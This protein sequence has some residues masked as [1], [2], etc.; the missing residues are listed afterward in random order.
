MNSH[1]LKG[2]LEYRRG[3]YNDR[4]RSAGPASGPLIDSNGFVIDPVGIPGGS[5]VLNDGYY[6]IRVDDYDTQGRTTEVGLFVRDDW[7]ITPHL[8]LN[9]GVRFDSLKASGTATEAAPTRKLDFSL[10]DM[11]G[12]RAGVIWDPFRSGR[13]RVFASFGRYYESVPAAVGDYAFG[14]GLIAAYYFYYPASGLPTYSNLGTFIPEV[15]ECP[16]DPAQCFTNPFRVA[17]SVGVDPDLRAQYSDEVSI[18]MEHELTPGFS[19]GIRGVDRRLHNV[20]EDISADG[21]ATYFITNPGG[22]YTS[23]PITGVPLET[24]VTF[25]VAERKYRALE[26]T[27]NKTLGESWRVLFRKLRL[28]EKRNYNLAVRQDN[29]QL[30]PNVTTVFDLPSLLLEPMGDCPT[31][32]L[33]RSSSTGPTSCPLDSSQDS[34]PST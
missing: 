7:Q 6:F 29:G 17:L 30:A 5:F 9:A 22:T 2:G 15:T 31:T 23:N 16:D 13:S 11:I 3:R 25:P 8:T 18:G 12:P 19:I 33:T 20:V 14:G 24:P 26:V 21:G 1:G 28:L 34:T 32:D 4:A 10:G 27:A